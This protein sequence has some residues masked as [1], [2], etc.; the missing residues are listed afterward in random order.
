M[1]VSGYLVSVHN[2]ISQLIST[3]MISQVSK[4]AYSHIFSW[5]NT[6]STY[7]CYY[8]SHLY[9]IIYYIL[10]REAVRYCYTKL[11]RQALDEFIQHW[12]YHHVRKS[13]SRAPG[14]KPELLYMQGIIGHIILEL[15]STSYRH[16]WAS[17]S[18]FRI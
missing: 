7:S 1:I 14:G 10:K 6:L 12:N 9:S 17:I 8:Y 15:I 3:G 11:V 16:L 13:G 5:K 18:S 2:N 4:P